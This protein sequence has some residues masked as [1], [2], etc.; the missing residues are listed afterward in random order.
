M[1]ILQLLRSDGHITINKFLA[2]TIGLYEAIILSE[3]INWF[4]FYESRDELDEENMFFFTVEKMEENTTLS[5]HQQSNAL[6]KLKELGVIDYRQK[7][8]PAKRYFSINT[9]AIESLINGDNKKLKNLTT[10][11]TKGFQD[12]IAQ[13]HDNSQ[14]LKNLTTGS[15]KIEQLEGQKLD[16]I[17]E[18]DKKNY[19]DIDL[20]DRFVDSQSLSEFLKSKPDRIEPE[21]IEQIANVYKSCKDKLT[22]DSFIEVLS[23]VLS[24]YKNNFLACLQTSLKNEMNKSMKIQNETKSS[25]SARNKKPNLKI[26][27]NVSEEEVV[28][29]EELA[30][31]REK[32]QRLDNMRRST[33]T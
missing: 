2:K 1:S 9:E 15:L 14:K 13:K 29:D 17:N 22:D 24:T 12:D 16:S 33:Q 28:T 8:L 3:L 18:L 27:G 30:E 7:G 19:I 10:D 11:N 4:L 32:A 20:I 25:R 21:H 23:R 5:K 6:K 31:M 26:V